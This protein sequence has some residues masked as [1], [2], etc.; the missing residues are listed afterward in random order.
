MRE[1]YPYSERIQRDSEYLS[2]FSPNAGKC[3][4][5][6]FLVNVLNQTVNVYIGNVLGRLYAF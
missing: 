3:G 6:I 4:P 2:I 1:K 5:G